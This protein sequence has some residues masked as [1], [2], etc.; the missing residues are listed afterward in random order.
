LSIVRQGTV[1]V[2]VV[3]GVGIAVG[4]CKSQ[5]LVFRL[6]TCAETEFSSV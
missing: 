5:W 6:A 2:F 3:I 4:F 1:C